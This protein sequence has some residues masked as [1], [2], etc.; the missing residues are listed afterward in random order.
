M[1]GDDISGIVVVSWLVMTSGMFCV[2][3]QSLTARRRADAGTGTSAW[4][5]GAL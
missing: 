4:N 1:V 5:N 3:S 2:L